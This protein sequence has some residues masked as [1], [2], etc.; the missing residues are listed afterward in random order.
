MSSSG[1]QALP[2]QIDLTN[3]SSSPELELVEHPPRTHP[4]RR[5][6]HPTRPI[7]PIS[8]TQ[9]SSGSAVEDAIVVL[10]SDDEERPDDQQ[11]QQ[12]PPVARSSLRIFSPPLAFNEPGPSRDLYQPRRPLVASSSG[13]RPGLGGGLLS[14]RRNIRPTTHHSQDTAAARQ[15]AAEREAIRANQRARHATRRHFLA[16]ALEVITR[17]RDYVQGYQDYEPILMDPE[18]HHH[19]H[20]GFGIINQHDGGIPWDQ[21]FGAPL[22]T[23]TPRQEEDE[24][25]HLWTHP[26]EKPRPGFTFDFDPQ[27]TSASAPIIIDDDEPSSS[28]VSATASKQAENQ[29]S[30]DVLLICARCNNPL[31]V[32]SRSMWGLRCGH[33]VCRDCIE[34]MTIPSPLDDGKGKGKAKEEDDVIHDHVTMGFGPLIVEENG[35]VNLLDGFTSNRG[36][37]KGKAARGRKGAIPPSSRTLRPRAAQSDNGPSTSP[38]RGRKRNHRSTVTK[39]GTVAEEHRYTCPV[40]GCGKDHWSVRVWAYKKDRTGASFVMDQDTNE[41]HWGEWVWKQKDNVGAIPIFT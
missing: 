37:G 10:D 21:G 16:R 25:R 26:A 31:L 34:K 19:Q 8:G 9:S 4:L 14:I 28:K 7:F 18:E 23:A 20:H 12:P 24:Y 3:R 36:K 32:G 11:R 33:V 35:A 29:S 17:T 27:M 5:P 15:Q 38:T 30:S 2:I 13:S 39:P 41:E 22:G 1:I 6:H 40:S